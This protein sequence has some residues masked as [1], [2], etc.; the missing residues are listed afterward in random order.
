[1]NKVNEKKKLYKESKE[2]DSWFS[3]FIIFVSLTLDNWIY[4]SF[5]ATIYFEGLKLLIIPL[6][7]MFC[8]PFE[9][10][11]QEYDLRC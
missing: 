11:T 9:E 8:D 2:N 5:I 4:S 6:S 7:S 1:M 3:A 10:L